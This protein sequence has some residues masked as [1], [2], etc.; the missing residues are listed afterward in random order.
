MWWVVGKRRPAGALEQD[1]LA[2]LAA[3]GSGL[4]AAQVRGRLDPAL[5]YTTVTT[6]L[7]RLAEKGAV[8]REPVG[9]AFAYRWAADSATLTARRMHRLLARED[10]RK[11]VLA[12]FVDGLGPADETVLLRLFNAAGQRNGR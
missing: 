9:R 1:V 11:A 2:V 6:T 12:R 10:D 7:A 4:T 5:A 3:A 8:T